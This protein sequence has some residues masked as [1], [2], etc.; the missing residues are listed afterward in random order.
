MAWEPTMDAARSSGALGDL[1][2]LLVSATRG[3]EGMPD[4]FLA[5][6]QQIHRELA[7]LSTRGEHRL[8]EGTDHYSLLM[9]RE[10]AL[11]VAGLLG[12][13]VVRTR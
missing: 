5:I 13:L 6:N 1:P 7:S 3:M 11:H 9:D 2:L 8:L 12:E 4:G 10:H